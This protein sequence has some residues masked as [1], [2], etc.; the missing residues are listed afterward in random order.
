[1]PH[2][3][4][5]NADGSVKSVIPLSTLNWQDAIKHVVLDTAYPL[6]NYEDW[7]IRSPSVTLQVPA[8]LM[9][10]RQ[11]KHKSSLRLTR[12][13]VFLRDAHTCQYCGEK[14]REQDLTWDHVLPRSHGGA[15]R[16]ENIVAA[17]SPCNT[18]RA[19]NVRIRPRKEPWK[20]SYYEMVAKRQEIPI[21]VAHE[22]WVPYM[23]WSEDMVN[24]RPKK[25]SMVCDVVEAVPV[26]SAT[27]RRRKHNRR[28]A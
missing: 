6:H 15:T 22:S 20:P 5:L 10:R 26:E 9:L 13:N 28:A 24:I 16:W 19:N 11:A 27:A 1:M 25:R 21:D 23:G 8:V 14:F 2:T 18:K 4:L 7:L 17:C 12:S 3:L